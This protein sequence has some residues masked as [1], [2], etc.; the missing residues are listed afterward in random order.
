MKL[1]K[2]QEK[3]ERVSVVQI[4][5]DTKTGRRTIT[6][7]EYISRDSNS[8]T[9]RLKIGCPKMMNFFRNIGC[10]NSKC[11]CWWRIKCSFLRKERRIS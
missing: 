4:H 9:K 3:T 11:T 2:K 6:P 7:A 8:Y 10:K 1:V 5:P